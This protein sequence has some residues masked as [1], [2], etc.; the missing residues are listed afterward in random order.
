MD[1]VSVIVPSY[2][3]F[4]YLLNTIDSMKKQTYKNMEIIVVNDCSTEREYYEYPF[5][6]ENVKII[7]LE[8]NS[9]AIYGFVC[10]NHVRQQGINVAQGNYI[11]FCDDDD[12]W[13]P[14]KIELQIEAM[15]RSGCKM[16]CSDGLI[17]HGIYNKNIPYK[18]YNKD[19]YYQTLQD[20]YRSHGSSLLDNGFPEIWSLDFL[21]IHNCVIASSAIVS[22]DILQENNCIKNEPNGTGDDYRIWL[23]VLEKTKCV[24]VDDIC[25]YYDLGHG[26]GQN[27]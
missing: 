22:K 2:N 12:I 11:A 19:H 23:R 18:K 25:F 4:N 20:I 8:K 15:K 5:E 27:Y 7:H 17:G 9:K 6:E 21:K 10:A 16:S 26:Y 24:Y 14:R 13:F 3:R 1:K